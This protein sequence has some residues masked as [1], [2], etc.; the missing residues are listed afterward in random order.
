M[1]ATMIRVDD[2]A[3]R[4]H[5]AKVYEAGQEQVFEHWEDLDAAERRSLL[6]QIAT[7]D[8]PEFVRLVRKG[9]EGGPA[10]AAPAAQLAPAE[11]VPLPADRG[12]DA[13][14]A[15][16]RAA[17]LDL[18]ARG[19]VGIF[20]V[21]GGQGTR[22]RFEGPKGCFPLL[23]ITGASL[24]QHFA[25]KIAALGRRVSRRIP[26][27]IMTSPGNDAAT[28]DFFRRHRHFGLDPDRI[29]FRQQ[30][31]LPVVDPRHGRILLA[32]RSELL[33]SPNGH[34][35]AVLVMQE[36]R[37]DLERF[38]VTTLFYHQVDN[39]LVAMADPVFLGHHRLRG[40]QFS[41]KAVAKSHPDEKVGVFC[42]EGERMR[43]IEYTELGTR[44]R[45]ARDREGRLAY[46]AGN[47]ATHAISTEFVAG[48]EPFRMPY[49]IARK[50]V[51]HLMGREVV[52]ATEPNS[53][54][55]ESFIFDLLPHA[56]NPV[57][58]EADRAREFAPVKNSEGENSPAAT[59]R[60]LVR[61]WAEWLEG[62]GVEIPRDA[63]G[64]P[65]HPIEI[66]PLVADSAEEL[67]AA[68][69]ERTV[70][71]RGPILLR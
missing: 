7:I 38:G 20:L 23:P 6:A 27:F 69:S 51:R 49:H 12:R 35:G 57:V 56:R 5:V 16:A 4:V 8:F 31:M 61:V 36:L 42:R 64:E 29:R 60:A 48:A 44:E 9:L 19:E 11:M 15:R 39:P 67:A 30:S 41:S 3:D 28:R 55:F 32:S 65:L 71:P 22:L 50:A 53:V 40:S 34:G 37:E 46:R 70:D 45:N 62:A 25:E 1:R 66:S 52:A 24:F 68:L 2:A 13:E 58:I 59:Q 47:I 54:R 10:G 33:L 18:L 21:A 17:G 63:A 26:W 43:V 14:T